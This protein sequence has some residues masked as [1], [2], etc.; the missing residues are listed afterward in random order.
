MDLPKLQLNLSLVHR[1]W[2]EKTTEISVFKCEWKHI[3]LWELD[4]AASISIS[5]TFPL[6]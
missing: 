1:Q 5:C 2:G 4:C 6:N 3:L